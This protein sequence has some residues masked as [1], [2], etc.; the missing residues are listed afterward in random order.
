MNGLD[1]FV[2]IVNLKFNLKKVLK[3]MNFEETNGVLFI[4]SNEPESIFVKFDDNDIIFWVGNHTAKRFEN[5]YSTVLDDI[6]KGKY[7]E[8]S[9][10]KYSIELLDMYGR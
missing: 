4:K 8:E 3:E 10:I 1:M 9:F 7:T 5:L 6:E 2:K